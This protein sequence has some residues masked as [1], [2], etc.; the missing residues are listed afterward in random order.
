MTKSL[1]RTKKAAIGASVVLASLGLGGATAA[2]VG[3]GSASAATGTSTPASQP[4]KGH[5]VRK[6]L[7]RHT[8]DATITVKTKN[9]YETL[10]LARGT[11]GSISPT[12]ITVDSP[13]GTTLTA[14][15]NAQT[16]FHNTTDQTLQLGDKVGVLA[17]E[18]VAKRINAPKTAGSSTTA[19]S[20]A[21]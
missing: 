6:Y 14:T 16:K 7:R 1:S 3:A 5:N 20:T 8:V 4:T 18:G 21:S 17:Y 9:G 13:D 12:S 11:V 10:D 15:I 19:P 2:F